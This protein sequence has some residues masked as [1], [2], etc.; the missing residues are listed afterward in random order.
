MAPFSV[1]TLL[2]VT[3][4]RSRHT[5]YLTLMGFGAKDQ[6]LGIIDMLP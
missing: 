3:T 2:S 1:T 5:R 6:N 4:L